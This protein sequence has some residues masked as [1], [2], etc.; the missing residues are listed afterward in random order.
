[1]PGLTKQVVRLVIERQ[2][3]ATPTPT[4]PRDTNMS[5]ADMQDMTDVQ[6]VDASNAGDNIIDTTDVE[7]VDADMAELEVADADLAELEAAMAALRVN[8]ADADV[9]DIDMLN[10]GETEAWVAIRQKE[11]WQLLRILRQ[12]RQHWKHQ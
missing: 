5:G 10:A 9:D 12:I 11:R 2:A 7:M 1:M 3:S 6:M 8:V 4:S